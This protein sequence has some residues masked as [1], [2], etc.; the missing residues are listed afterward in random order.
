MLIEK[1]RPAVVEFQSTEVVRLRSPGG[2]QIV[3]PTIQFAAQAHEILSNGYRV[4]VQFGIDYQRQSEI[5]TTVRETFQSE[6]ERRWRESGWARSLVDVSVEF[7]SAGR[8]ALDYF[9]RVDLDGSQAIDYASQR[10]HLASICVDV[11]N[12]NGWV[13]P[14]TQ[15]TVHLA[16][17]IEQ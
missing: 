7:S 4:D 8:S 12:Q 10:R 11:C 16:P 14:F 15:M 2:N 13:I 6:V 17:A 3:V 5:T 9:V 1:G